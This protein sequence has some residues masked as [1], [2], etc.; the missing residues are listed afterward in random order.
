MK[1]SYREIFKYIIAQKSES[2]I[3]IIYNK[4]KYTQFSDQQLNHL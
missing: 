4:Y 3:S 1:I 2:N